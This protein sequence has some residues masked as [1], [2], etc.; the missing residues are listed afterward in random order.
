MSRTVRRY[1]PEVSSRDA[2]IA[3]TGRLLRRQGY[4]ATGVNEIV[5][6]SG[7]PR[8]SLY[9][10]FPGG[11]EELALAAMLREGGKLRAAIASVMGSSDDPGTALGRL[12]DAL[13]HGLETSGFEDGCPIATVTLE[14]ATRSKGVQEA[15]AAIFDSWIQAL[16]ERLLAGGLDVS[17]ARRRAVLALAAIEGALIL[18][19]ARRDLEP[20]AAVREELVSLLA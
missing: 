15:A 14:A 4:D 13:A 17:T 6:E 16:E 3:A 20:L 19:R 1:V 12:V 7:A 5:G 18:A 10:H 9:F 11:K 8:G 2:F